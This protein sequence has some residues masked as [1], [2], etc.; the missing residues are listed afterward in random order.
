VIEL[1]RSKDESYGNAWKK[2]GEQVSIAANIARKVD[3][4]ESVA[5]G[6]NPNDE[7]FLDTAVDLFVY[8]L[9][10]Q[11]FLA[12]QDADVA[13]QLFGESTGGPYSEGPSGF[14]RLIAGQSFLATA[15]ASLEGVAAEVVANF[16]ALD[17]YL[18]DP[19]SPAAWIDR[20]P[21]IET[22]T[23]SALQLVLADAALEQYV[24]SEFVARWAATA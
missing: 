24:V 13:A 21:F 10:Y 16:N 7:T 5:N 2:R 14:D 15:S 17:S 8:C 9:K 1:H 4:I 23:A 19:N 12:D 22:L 18:R 3:R 11:T 20:L 6:A